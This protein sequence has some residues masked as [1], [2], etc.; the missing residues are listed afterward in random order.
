MELTELFA[1]VARMAGAMSVIRLLTV[2]IEGN[3]Q[4]SASPRTTQPALRRSRQ[5]ERHLSGC[6]R[7]MPDPQKAFMLLTGV[8]PPA[9]TEPPRL[10]KA[11]FSMATVVE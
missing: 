4:R 8:P 2:I 1:Q 10:L 6:T 11:T 5:E 7:G 9:T 3:G